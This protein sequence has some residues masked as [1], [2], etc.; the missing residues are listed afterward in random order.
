MTKPLCIDDALADLDGKVAALERCLVQY[1]HG[2]SSWTSQA[3]SQVTRNAGSVELMGKELEQRETSVRNDRTEIERQHAEAV[4]LKKACEDRQRELNELAELLAQA[5]RDSAVKEKKLRAELGQKQADLETAGQA[6][7]EKVSQ[8]DSMRESN[9]KRIKEL[10][11]EA[12]RQQENRV[13][14]E[15]GCTELKTTLDARTKESECR[16]AQLQEKAEHCEEEEERLHILA[17]QFEEQ[18]SQLENQARGLVARETDLVDRERALSE[19]QAA[20]GV[21][22]CRFDESQQQME[23]ERA[24]TNKRKEQLEKQQAQLDRQA[25][26]QKA[27][28]R[29]LSAQSERLA[30]D[31]AQVEKARIAA[32]ELE[33]RCRAQE[34]SLATDRSK[35]EKE[36][37][38]LESQRDHLHSLEASLQTDR[39]ELVAA[40]ETFDAQTAAKQIQLVHE[41][42]QLQVKLGH[43]SQHENELHN[44]HTVIERLKEEFERRIAQ[45]GDREADLVAQQAKLEA[46]LASIQDDRLAVQKARSMADEVAQARSDELAKSRQEVDVLR[47]EIAEL[48]NSQDDLQRVLRDS[49]DATQREA[50][51]AETARRESQVAAAQ[52]E[53]SKMAATESA[54]SEY[55][56]QIQKAEAAT[57]GI[58]AELEAARGQRKQLENDLLNALEAREQTARK[59]D[60]ARVELERT[61]KSLEQERA[62]WTAQMDALKERQN[63]ARLAVRNADSINGPKDVARSPEDAESASH[64][65]VGAYWTSMA[66]SGQYTIQVA[67]MKEGAQTHTTDHVTEMSAPQECSEMGVQ[68][69]AEDM[70]AAMHAA[71]AAAQAEVNE[72]HASE[73]AS[74]TQRSRAGSKRAKATVPVSLKEPARPST[75]APETPAP[76]SKATPK[77]A[78]PC[79][80]PV[81]LD[82]ETRQKLKMLK[83][84][85]PNKSESEL[86]AAIN[87]ENAQPAKA[88][89]KRG[90]LR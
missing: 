1:Q 89:T 65:G 25:Q 59:L 88:K 7:S 82:A 63:E 16:D 48:R 50:A 40:R 2:V 75:T 71:L 79:E 35:L 37:V 41:Q 24:E 80:T 30:K 33:A 73:A 39:A 51:A 23:S 77:R 43:A 44:E 22:E 49:R 14:W 10:E 34:K 31:K 72:N 11:C 46:A 54:L 21:R 20:Y 56:Q 8:A 26:E 4:E 64:A 29:E 53:S 3:I 81:E 68:V 61:G 28:E 62:Q 58:R 19:T 9:E 17:R 36:K 87:A 55:Q 76:S 83:R 90:W 69:P 74:A 67:D 45:T 57:A 78:V 52:A 66:A 70:A 27:R 47:A 86:L 38:A 6:L 15:R 42:D 12:K 13:Q 85:N 5:Q 18:K 84:L 60:E 32:G